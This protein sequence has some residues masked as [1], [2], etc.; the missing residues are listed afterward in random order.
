MSTI[1]VAQEDL[2]MESNRYFASCAT[3][4]ALAFV[5]VAHAATMFETMDEASRLAATYR[6]WAPS[7]AIG[8]SASGSTLTIKLRQDSK[9]SDWATTWGKKLCTNQSLAHYLG[10]GG[11]LS[12]NLE[13]STGKR[14]GDMGG[15]GPSFCKPFG[16]EIPVVNAANQGAPGSSRPTRSSGPMPA[17]VPV[18][19]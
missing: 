6:T 7:E 13:D 15:G 12:V 11:S 1:S 10:M 8:V 3:S 2:P 9:S 19:R 4:L 16:I 18:P 17:S 5:G 14:F